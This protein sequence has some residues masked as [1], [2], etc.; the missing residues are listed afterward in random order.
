MGARMVTKLSARGASVPNSPSAT[1][2]GSVPSVSDVASDGRPGT[3]PQANPAA[4]SRTQRLAG[5]FKRDDVP[6]RGAQSN[7]PRPPPT[8][9]ST[10][11]RTFERMRSAFHPASA[12]PSSGAAARSTDDA[13]TVNENINF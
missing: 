13:G 5:L 4:P 7:A 1:D 9:L 3:I 6:L 2:V 12:R 8:T 10:A 11:A